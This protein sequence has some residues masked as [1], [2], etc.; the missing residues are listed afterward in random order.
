MAPAKKI[1]PNSSDEPAGL[2]SNFEVGEG[3]ELPLTMSLRPVQVVIGPVGAASSGVE[4]QKAPEPLT[5]SPE[6]DI[7]TFFKNRTIEKK[8]SLAQNFLF[9]V[10]STAA[11][12]VITIVAS[13]NYSAGVR[14]QVQAFGSQY[15][16]INLAE[17]MPSWS[18]QSKNFRRTNA[19]L[20]NQRAN[21]INGKGH[22]IAPM[23]T[24]MDSQYLNVQAG[25]W[26]A[27]EVFSADKCS[28]WAVNYACSVRAWYLSY[29]GM[30][31][32]LRP[33]ATLDLS[34]NEAVLPRIRAMLIFAKS[35]SLSGHVSEQLF[36]EAIALIPGEKTLKQMLF[37]ARFKALLLGNQ[38]EEMNTMIKMIPSLEPSSYLVAKWRALDVANRLSNRSSTGGDVARGAAI[39]KLNVDLG[40]MGGGLALDPV[41]H[42]MLSKSLLRLGLAKPVLKYA[43]SFELTQTD[44][45][46]DPGLRDAAANIYVRALLLNGDKKLALER[47]TKMVSQNQMDYIGHQ[48]L[49]SI[50]LNSKSSEDSV[51]A[52]AS[53]K[54]SLKA[55]PSWEAET[56]YLLALTRS[57]QLNEGKKVA[58]KLPRLSNAESADWVTIAISEYRMAEAKRSQVKVAAKYN[59]VALS[60]ASVFARHPGWTRLAG[61]YAEA[62]IGA[63]KVTEGAKI[64]LKI[65]DIL[66][67]TS[68][69]STPEYTLSPFGPLALMRP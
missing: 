65:D 59:E 51:R 37:D 39:T 46:L 23:E 21:K 14:T 35:S 38:Q 33:L 53:F 19:P 54:A 2:G 28:K 16:Q 43:S 56:G 15:L 45:R 27:V 48:L 8:S 55:H 52:V 11:C 50:Y 10:V 22:A 3:P 47:L 49:G 6:D 63:T 34:A 61:L 58:E 30:K 41:A 36:H 42:L 24:P 31:G 29:R 26:P 67:K 60:L 17:Y 5:G 7:E 20:I 44:N 25:A 32:L 40:K 62:L 57:G 13:W 9:Q 18:N 66:S 64:R 1:K 12:V 68:Y 4:T 69:F